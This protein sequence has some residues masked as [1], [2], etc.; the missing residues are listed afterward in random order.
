MW[1][2]PAVEIGAL[3]IWDMSTFRTSLQAKK[4]VSISISISIIS[5]IGITSIINII[6]LGSVYKSKPKRQNQFAMFFCKQTTQATI[7]L[8]P[9][10]SEPMFTFRF[11]LDQGGCPIG[12]RDTVF[13][14]RI[15]N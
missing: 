2:M 4:N 14:V 1:D 5:I 3:V 11:R 15:W 9:L 6:G 10:E 13:P 7:I 12:P 8:Y